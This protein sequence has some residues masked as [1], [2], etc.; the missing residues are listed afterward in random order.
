MY[1]LNL[2]SPVIVFSIVLLILTGCNKEPDTPA[3]DT[4]DADL[5]TLFDDSFEEVDAI[6]E[7]SL[8]LYDIYGRVA[9]S[10]EGELEELIGCA[11]KNHDPDNQKITID[12]GDGCIGLLGRVRKG[13]III[14]YTD[15]VFIPGSKT[16]ITFD[17][18][19]VND[20]KV[21]GI[22]TLENVSASIF[23]APEFYIKLEGGRLTWPEEK[24]GG[25][26]EREV[27]LYKTW[28]RASNPLNDEFIVEGVASGKNRNGVNYNMRILSAIKYK[29]AC[30]AA[31]VFLPVEGVKEVKTDAKEVLIDFGN[32]EC[33]RTITIMIDGIVKEYQHTWPGE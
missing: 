29:R 22:R 21:E 27:Y 2:R 28:M 17:N 5:E 24:G 32:G 30:W 11:I 26:A 4:S 10:T 6:V 7:S 14:T 15:K 8:A 16:V 23:E 9:E 12:F 19:Y 18:F 13:I 33:D 1:F 3:L 20:I 31:G 25:F